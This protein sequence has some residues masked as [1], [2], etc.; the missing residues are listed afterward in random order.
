MAS[1]SQTNSFIIIFDYIYFICRYW[2]FPKELFVTSVLSDKKKIVSHKCTNF[3]SPQDTT[4][5]QRR[6]ER[7]NV[8]ACPKTSPQIRPTIKL[9]LM[10]KCLVKVSRVRTKK[11]KR[12]LQHRIFLFCT[13]RPF[14]TPQLL[15]AASLPMREIV[16]KFYI[17]SIIVSRTLNGT[18]WNEHSSDREAATFDK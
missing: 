5:I 8:S 1:L 9:R 16:F 13:L 7:G 6:V 11:K 15:I 17:I 3:R 4:D 18:N 14:W 10:I 12:N 2:I